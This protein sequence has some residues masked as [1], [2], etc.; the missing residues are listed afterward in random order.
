[1]VLNKLLLGSICDSMQ[2]NNFLPIEYIL[3]GFLIFQLTKTAV[4]RI[5]GNKSPWVFM[6]K[7]KGYVLS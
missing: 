2:N 5:K 1:M 6:V 7:L 3:S 4:S